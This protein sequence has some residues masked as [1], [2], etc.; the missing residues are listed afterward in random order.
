MSAYLSKQYSTFYLDEIKKISMYKIVLF[1]SHYEYEILPYAEVVYRYANYAFYQEQNHLINKDSSHVFH[2]KV[3]HLH[4]FYKI[5]YHQTYHYFYDILKYVLFILLIFCTLFTF[6]NQDNLAVSLLNKENLI[7][8]KNDEK[9]DDNLNTYELKQNSVNISGIFDEPVFITVNSQADLQ[10]NVS[11]SLLCEQISFAS[12]VYI[13]NQIHYL[14][15]NEVILS[16][17]LYDYCQEVTK[18]GEIKNLLNFNF[19]GVKTFSFDKISSYTTNYQEYYSFSFPNR[20]TLPQIKQIKDTTWNYFHLI[21]PKSY[22]Q[23]MKLSDEDLI[24][25]YQF[26]GMTTPNSYSNLSFTVDNRNIVH[27]SFRND[28]AIHP[29]LAANEFYYFDNGH[30]LDADSTNENHYIIGNTYTFGFMI[31][32]EEVSYDL[33]YKGYDEEAPS[34]YLGCYYLNA[35]LFVDLI[36]KDNPDIVNLGNLNFYLENPSKITIKNLSIVGDKE[37]AYL[38]E[39]LSKIN[40]FS[41]TQYSG[42]ILIILALLIILINFLNA[43]LNKWEN[44]LHTLLCRGFTKKEIYHKLHCDFL[45]SCALTS[46]VIVIC[47]LV[48]FFGFFSLFSL[49]ISSYHFYLILLI[50][51]GTPILYYLLEI[52]PY[53]KK[54]R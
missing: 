50:I 20:H 11:Y 53:L 17:L 33:V 10:E 3:N 35:D 31:N 51:L 13:D 45:L 24:T 39:Y 32:G 25:H 38:D 43:K 7:L 14:D 27:G 28:L 12:Y 42:Y 19:Y 23:Y 46:L 16:D 5:K 1:I 49:F 26:N 2:H 22:E 6:S 15:D 52:I 44:N 48:G 4:N 34:T 36:K 9:N 40:I 37:Y 29:S 18:I 47:G 30:Y 21:L 54:I 8:L 41:L